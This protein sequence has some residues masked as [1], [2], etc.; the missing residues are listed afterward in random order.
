MAFTGFVL[1]A[2]SL[3]S[4][5]T[6]MTQS[7][8]LVKEGKYTEALAVLNEALEKKPLHPF[9]L[10]RRAAIY[11]HNGAL[12]KAA[13]DIITAS[14]AS[15]ESQQDTGERLLLSEL[16]RDLDNHY[17][18]NA[19]YALKQY[20]YQEAVLWATKSINIDPNKA[21][22]YHYRGVLRDKNEDHYGAIE[23][24]SKSIAMNQ[25]AGASPNIN[26][27]ST[28]SSAYADIGKYTLALKDANYAISLDTS[29][30]NSYHNRGYIRRKLGDYT[31]ALADFQKADSL[32][33]NNSATLMQIADT[34]NT[35]GV[36]RGNHGDTSGEC[37][38]Y[39]EALSYISRAKEIALK[40]D[41][42]LYERIMNSG[43]TISS[44]RSKTACD[45]SW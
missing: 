36:N 16:K 13:S 37:S 45:S 10:R 35:I 43:R 18:N 20:N 26:S 11:L 42:S 17:L 7:D 39:D 8:Q 41:P 12:D 40:G 27:Y 34:L 25:K 33:P 14:N 9:A 31:G 2:C 24:L 32:E 19:Q 23:D 29:H 28:R 5:E 4:F 30:A 21:S 44:N 22:N 15:D 38:A 6:L 1:S 3:V